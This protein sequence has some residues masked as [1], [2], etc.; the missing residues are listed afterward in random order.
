MKSFKTVFKF[1]Y[2][3][4]I[5]SKSFIVVTAILLLIVLVGGNMPAIIN[6]VG[7]L[8]GSGGSGG[9]S[10]AGDADSG[11]GKADIKKAAFYSADETYE[12]SLLTAYNGAY[13]WVRV[14]ASE[15]GGIEA[16]IERGDYEV[17]LEIN[18]LE[19]TVYEKGSNTLMSSFYDFSDLVKSIYQRETLAAE[20]MDDA[21]IDGILNAEVVRNS[22]TVGKDAGQSFWMGYIMLFMLYFTIILYG[23]YVST[24]VITEKTSKAMELLIT[25]SKPMPLMFGKVI[26]T[27]LA[28]LTQFGAFI[29]SAFVMLKLNAPGWNALSPEVGGIVDMTLSNA[30][31]FIF[32][33][34]FFFIGF[35]MFSFLFAGAASTV[36]RQED[37][38]SVV[39]IPMLLFIASFMVAMTGMANAAA[40]YI[41]VCS[42]IP[43]L[44]PLVM[45]MRICLIDVP[46][47]E[48]AICIAA[49]ILYL[50]GAGYVSA[51][52]YR[53][54]VMLYGVKPTPR[55]LLR[56]IR[57]A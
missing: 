53:V 21:Q 50:L 46:A 4:Y 35:F 32:A 52:I 14:S 31:V 36:S 54:G 7:A 48:I 38:Q 55:D 15:M 57:Q 24:S 47:V 9:D 2:T 42:F 22:V 6:L 29:V 40:Q 28:G 34:V 3:N 44:S 25:S 41:R 26:G 56:Y 45:F 23:Q 20:G 12:K 8:T 43:F 13:D 19:Y 49:N 16:M 10:A 11:R 1:E 27:G 17:A 18:G 51:K 37:A 30:G 33:L 39:M 5:K